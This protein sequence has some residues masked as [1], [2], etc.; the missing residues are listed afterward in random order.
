LTPVNTSQIIEESE[1]SVYGLNTYN[2]EFNQ[3]VVLKK[4]TE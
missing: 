3:H 1:G 4:I 2:L